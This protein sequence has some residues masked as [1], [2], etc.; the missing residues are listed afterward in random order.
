MP[1][2]TARDGRLSHMAR[3]ILLELLSRPDGWEAT[4]DDMWRESL[5]R[6]G[7]SSPGR[8]AFRSAF[9]E[10]KRHGYLV[11]GLDSL[12][13]GRHGTVLTLTDIPAA[14]TEVPDAGTPDVVDALDIEALGDGPIDRSDVPDAGTSVPPADMDVSAG[15]SDV[16]LSDVPH[17]GT[18]NRKQSKK[19]GKEKTG[20]VADAVGKGAGGF[21]PAGESD[22]A[23]AESDQP[24]GGCAASRTA[25]PT[26]RKKSP[27]P[28]TTKTVP[29][30]QSPAFELVRAA[31][32]AEVAKPGTTLFPGLHRAINDLLTGTPT[33]G[34]PSRTPDQVIA[35]LNRRWYGEQADRRSAA[36]YRGCDRCTATGC[37][38]VRRSPDDPDGCDR[39]KNR[40]SWLAAAILAQDCPNPSCEDGQLIGAGACR[41]CQEQHGEHRAAERAAAAA[42]ARIQEHLD[43]HA[44]AAAAL[45]A[46]TTAETVEEHRLRAA[47]GAAGV[48]SVR[49]D[50]Q[51]HQHMTGWRDRNPKPAPT[52]DDQQRHRAPQAPVQGAFL[53]PVPT[54]STEEPAAPHAPAE[55]SSSRQHPLENCDG[56]DRAHRPTTPGRPCA[57]C[58]TEQRAVNTA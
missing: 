39:I 42:A 40:N 38:N 11:A 9:A 45:D 35:R 55:R 1:N 26:Q 46:W 30:Q 32:P 19:T 53:V 50:H 12:E 41:A 2:A 23:G 54:G 21:A 24:E 52:R 6:H 10:L 14:H 27:R 31:I 7:K 18:S 37:H 16:P 58:R 36:A 33:A 48:Y 4:A 17:A 47:L 3:G 22:S 13:G 5:S 44:A 43:T 15:R 57:T 28:A 34:I 8:R 25:P 29:R 20:G 51:V 49:L 56:C